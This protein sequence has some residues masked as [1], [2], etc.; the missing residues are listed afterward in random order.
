MPNEVE[1]GRR[2]LLLGTMAAAIAG[3]ARAQTA[4][5]APQPAQP[6]AGAV[7]WSTGTERPRLRVPAN[8]CDCHHHIYDSK[9]PA[10]ANAV[11]LPPDAS[12]AD[13]RALQRRLGTTRNVIVQPSTYG[14]DNRVTLD[15]MKE[16]GANTRAVAVVNAEVS[17]AELRRLHD[18][19][20]RGIRFN[21]QQAGATTIDM[22]EPLS[23]RIHGMG[24]HCQVFMPGEK[25][26]EA[27]DLFMRL[28]SRLVFDHLGHVPQPAGVE[29]PTFATVRALIDKGNT[30]V[31]LSGAYIDTRVGP[32]GYADT[33]AVARAYAAH[34][35][36]RM[37]WGSDWPHPTQAAD[38]KPDDAV[39]LDLLAAWVPDEA[40]RNR[41]LVDN[42][43]ELYDFPRG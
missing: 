41:I 16:M 43:A 13:Y 19:G 27:R 10:A 38:Q 7:R 18:L 9:Y 37:V 25:L 36:Q 14:T 6:A 1:S 26:A 34:A 42:P 20:V 32:P 31:K 4:G 12:I 33:S 17:D 3:T 30:W 15:A 21:L 40:A 8:A 35:P 23:R 24:W 5:Q 22:L 11:L 29:S 2:P 39:L 28:P